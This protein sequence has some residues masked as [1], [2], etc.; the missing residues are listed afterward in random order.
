MGVRSTFFVKHVLKLQNKR[1]AFLCPPTFTQYK[2]NFN[3]PLDNYLS[4]FPFADLND[5]RYVNVRNVLQSIDKEAEIATRKSQLVDFI[6]RLST[7]TPAV[8]KELTE[9][10]QGLARHP[11]FSEVD[12]EIVFAEICRMKPTDIIATRNF[13]KT[14]YEAH[15]I[16]RLFGIEHKNLDRLS[17]LLSDHL[18]SA[19][20]RLSTHA[21]G[22]LIE[23]LQEACG[24]LQAEQAEID[25][26]KAQC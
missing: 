26:K 18:K 15:G 19:Q 22:V 12:P 23:S 10:A 14:R 16:G 1:V 3:K 6:K 17:K 5:P 2:T 11:I 9:G 13:I 7:D 21:I 8:I 25:T 24:H 20:P 4:S